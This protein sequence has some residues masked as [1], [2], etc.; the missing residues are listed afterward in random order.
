LQQSYTTKVLWL[1]SS[2]AL[3]AILWVNTQSQSHIC[4]DVEHNIMLMEEQMNIM[5]LSLDEM[6]Y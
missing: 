1:V 6:A 3:A 2:V 5:S 4:V